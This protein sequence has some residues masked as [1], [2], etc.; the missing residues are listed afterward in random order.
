M[1]IRDTALR[2]YF[3]GVTKGSALMPREII[4][5]EMKLKF[6]TL[7]W[8]SELLELIEFIVCLK[9]KLR[10]NNICDAISLICSKIE[11]RSA[12]GLSDSIHVQYV[13]LGGPMLVYSITRQLAVAE[14]RQLR[15]ARAIVQ[16]VLSLSTLRTYVRNQFFRLSNG[17]H[18]IYKAFDYETSLEKLLLW[19]VYLLYVSI[20]ILS[21]RI[22]NPA[23]YESTYWFPI[24]KFLCR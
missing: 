10:A 9:M 7:L 12:P 5:R 13:S 2:K 16:C 22:W 11:C 1:G 20:Y 17:T 23:S 15:S 21:T 6:F 3:P 4:F 24:Y 8:R 14:C 19:C 18:S